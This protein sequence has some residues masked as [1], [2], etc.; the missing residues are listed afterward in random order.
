M[1]PHPSLTRMQ[2]PLLFERRPFVPR[3]QP[4][5][6]AHCDGKEIGKLWRLILVTFV[7]I[8]LRVLQVRLSL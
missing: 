3:K 4:I 8:V 1:T 7:D 5:H 6:G 2:V